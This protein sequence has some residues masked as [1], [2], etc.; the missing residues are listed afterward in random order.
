[1]N[2]DRWSAGDVPNVMRVTGTKYARFARIYSEG[3]LAG[4]TLLKGS[5]RYDEGSRGVTVVMKTGGLPRQ[6]TDEPN[7]VVWTLIQSLIPALFGAQPYRLPVCIA[8][9]FCSFDFPDRQ[10]HSDLPQKG[11]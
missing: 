2:A 11:G 4:S 8:C 9:R 5:H 10:F 7:V 6:P 3:R 1:V